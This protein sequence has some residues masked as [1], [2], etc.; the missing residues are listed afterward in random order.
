MP[1]TRERF[2]RKLEEAKREFGY[3]TGIIDDHE[4]EKMLR[5]CTDELWEHL[6]SHQLAV[7]MRAIA[8]ALLD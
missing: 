8:T 7:V 3:T 4:Q 5:R 1:N 6:T 2:N